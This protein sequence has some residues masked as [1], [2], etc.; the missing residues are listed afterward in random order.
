MPV[1][2]LLSVLPLIVALGM[3]AVLRRSG[4]QTSIATLVVVIVLVLIVPSLRLSPLHLLFALGSGFSTSLTVLF[5]LF[6]ALVLYQLE[7]TRSGMSI[8]AQG[9]ARLCPDRDLL[10]LAI[11]LGLAPFA[12]AVSGF[13]TGTVIVIPILIAVGFDPMRA[14]ILGLLGQFAVPWGGL[15]VGITLG[16]QLTHLDSGIIGASTA[17]LTAPFPFFFGFVALY[18][19]GG[20]LAI[21]HLLLPCCIASIVV[22]F[23]LWLFSLVPGV[24]LA[25]ALACLLSL[26]FLIAWGYF[27]ARRTRKSVS[28][29]DV[30]STSDHEHTIEN[31]THP[32]AAL[33]QAPLPLWRVVA[34]YALLVVVLLLTRLITP[35]SNWLQTH[36][37]LLQ[38]A[39]SLNLPVLY[40]PG[41]LLLLAA[42]ATIPLLHLD[43][44]EAWNTLAKTWN[45]FLPAAI[46]ILCFLIVG[47]V[48]SAS[49]MTTTL[50]IAAARL[51]NN[52]AWI[53]PWLGA[54]GGWLTGS[55][56]GGNAMFALLQQSVSNRIGL[57]LRWVMGA[58]NG[59]GSV[60]TMVSPARLILAATAAGLL[61]KESYLLR[62]V[63]PL[64]LIAVALVMV[65]LVVIIY[66]SR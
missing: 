56:A 26:T 41:V 38:P 43:G 27:M 19:S 36:V 54:L 9:I 66:I 5:I 46:A 65:L 31:T 17:L 23:G 62:R 52:Y 15:A 59:A 47:Q 24:E 16:A 63:G 22:V 45:Q 53:A 10:V 18:M 39:I 48:M 14:A 55:N 58:Q 12:E 8:L 30:H 50:G 1:E 37:I 25:G 6:P 11:V 51:G 60:A 34:P 29:L 33:S 28:T 7:Q 3:L 49:G 2:I 35:L 32:V 21:R 44:H 40:T 42:A 61:G 20:W 13:G 64:V 57:P 4:L